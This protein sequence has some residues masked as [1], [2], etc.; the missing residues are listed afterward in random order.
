MER[1]TE[2]PNMK[3]LVVRT[4]SFIYI[5]LW[6]NHVPIRPIPSNYHGLANKTPPL[7]KISREARE[8]N[9]GEIRSRAKMLEENKISRAKILGYFDKSTDLKV[10]PGI[11]K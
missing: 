5:P 9:W 4:A 10:N 8:K 2:S 7:Y 1:V 6:H 3:N 11:Q